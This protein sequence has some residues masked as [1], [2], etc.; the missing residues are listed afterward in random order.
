MTVYS[1]LLIQIQNVN[2][3]AFSVLMNCESV[4]WLRHSPNTKFKDAST[5]PPSPPR[6]TAQSVMEEANVYSQFDWLIALIPNRG[7]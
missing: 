7:N 6:R 2:N 4:Q 5:L 1:D 3:K